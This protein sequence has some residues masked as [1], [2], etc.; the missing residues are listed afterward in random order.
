MKSIN[1]DIKSRNDFRERNRKAERIETIKSGAFTVALALGLL[2]AFY[3]LVL[4]VYAI[5]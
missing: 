1:N 4:A 3:C 2:V 5:N